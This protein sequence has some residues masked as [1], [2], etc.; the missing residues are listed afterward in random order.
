MSVA[1]L[2][3]VVLLSDTRSTDPAD[4]CKASIPDS[5][6][7]AISHQFRGYRLPKEADNLAEDIQY[8]RQHGGNGCLGVATGQFGGQGG[9]DVAILLT[10][11]RD[12]ILVVAFPAGS[13]WRAERVW[14]AGDASYRMRLYVDRADPGKYDD[15]GLSDSREPGQVDSF[16]S[17]HDVV[18][19]GA[20]ESTGMAFFKGPKGWVHVWISD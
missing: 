14:K 12:V 6:R 1:W 3:A 9:T 15:L 16:T 5:L 20:T 7:T 17:R 10:S 2:L 4:S 19:T 18:V 8:N 11:K 13:G